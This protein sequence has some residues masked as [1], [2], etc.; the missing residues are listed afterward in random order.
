MK[1]VRYVSVPS[2]LIT[3]F[4]MGWGLVF[5]GWKARRE[6]HQIVLTKGK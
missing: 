5:S 2:N 4:F 3:A 6:D 1:Q